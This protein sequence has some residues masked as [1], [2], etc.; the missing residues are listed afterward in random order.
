M[1]GS[2]TFIR[3]HPTPGVTVTVA[4]EPREHMDDDDR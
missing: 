2:N 3:S 1:S 4:E